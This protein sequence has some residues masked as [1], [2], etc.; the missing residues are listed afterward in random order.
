MVALGRW[1]E[2]REES[3][4]AIQSPKEVFGSGDLECMAARARVRSLQQEN[5]WFIAQRNGQ[6]VSGCVGKS[7]QKPDVQDCFN[8]LKIH[9]FF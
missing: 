8:N 2:G 6:T 1:Q 3:L 5:R 4:K 9:F 7:Q